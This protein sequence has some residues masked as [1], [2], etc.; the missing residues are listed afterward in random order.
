MQNM[1]YDG[2]IWEGVYRSFGDAPAA[3]RGFDGETWVSK[4]ITKL[5]TVLEEAG[6]SAFLP[7]PSNYRECLLPLL[8]ALACSEKGNVRVL[9][10]GGGIGFTYYQTARGMKGAGGIEYHIVE[11]ESVCSAGKSLFESRESGPSFFKDLSELGPGL[12]DIVHLGSS[13]HYVEEWRVMLSRLCALSRMYLLLVDV[14]AGDIPTFATAQNYYESKIPVWFFNIE[15]MVQAVSS[16]G[17]EL[18]FSSSYHPTLLG[19]EA[20]VP[21]QNFE[22]K[23]RLK[24]MCNLLFKKVPGSRG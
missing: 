11:R 1:G 22:E 18:I 6:E 13:I 9:D 5:K 10:F 2:A 17:Y 23:Y 15:E 8:A 20:K 19:T 12:Y 16:F 4:S 14:P 24:R 21:M 7:P 3:G